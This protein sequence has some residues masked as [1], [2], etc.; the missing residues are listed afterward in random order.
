[1]VVAVLSMAGICA[2]GTLGALG[3]IAAPGVIAGGLF[4]AAM[5][6]LATGLRVRDIAPGDRSARV[7]AGRRTGL[8]VG[9]VVAVG[10]AMCTGSALLLGPAAVAL[11]LFVPII[12]G[13][14]LWRRR[15]RPTAA[16]TPRHVHVVAGLL[17][18]IEQP[19]APEPCPRPPACAPSPAGLSTAQ[20]CLAWQHSYFA[21]LDLAAGASATD[22]VHLREALLDEFERRD[23]AGFTRWID[24]DAR[25]GSNP[26]RFV[27]GD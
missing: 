9:C 2:G 7:S 25:P 11:L 12:I 21:L 10:W 26:G 15:F 8:F 4:C 24:A 14:A 20:L 16:G 18:W 17:R 5:T 13:A 1:L 22:L 6:G 23:P 27:V 3:A 19:P